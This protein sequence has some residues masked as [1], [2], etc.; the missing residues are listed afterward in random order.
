M[1]NK[2]WPGFATGPRS[3]YHRPVRQPDSLQR[4]SQ[5]QGGRL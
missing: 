5:T 2:V 3:N 4:G 1:A